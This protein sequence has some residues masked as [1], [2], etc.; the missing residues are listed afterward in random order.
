[1]TISAVYT[2]APGEDPEELSHNEFT[3]GSS[4]TLHCTV[5]GNSSGLTYD[6]SVTENPDTPGCTDCSIDTSSTTSQLALGYPALNSYFAGVYMCTVAENG[7]PDSE[8]N[9]NFTV[10]VIGEVNVNIDIPN[11]SLFSK[12]AGLYADKRTSSS[13]F[14]PG[15][16]ANNSLVIS[17]DDRLRLLCVSNSS[18]TGEEIGNFT[19]SDGNTHSH[20]TTIG[21]WRVQNPSSSPGVLRLQTRS[22]M[23]MAASDQGIYTCTIPDSND[24]TFV[25]NVGLYP[26]D[27][28]GK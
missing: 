1:M 24:N 17:A 22:G 7:T 5:Q 12:G 18:L 21:I 3:A 9:D 8:N 4:L 14:L 20:D 27:F 15:P 10:I 28:S 23:S 2:P 13:T 11:L 25:F 26:N 6:W 19:L 16:I